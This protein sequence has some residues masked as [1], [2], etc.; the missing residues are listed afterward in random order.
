[1][2]SDFNLTHVLKYWS[3]ELKKSQIC[4]G[5]IKLSEKCI[6][7][8]VADVI[9][10]RR[11]EYDAYGVAQ[12]F[13][14]IYL[15]LSVFYL[16]EAEVGLWVNI[17]GSSDLSA[18]PLLAAA[19]RAGQVATPGEAPDEAICTQNGTSFIFLSA[20]WCSRVHELFYQPSNGAKHFAMKNSIMNN[21]L[22]WFYT[23]FNPPDSHLISLSRL[24]PFYP[25][26]STG[27]N[28]FTSSTSFYALF[29]T[30]KWN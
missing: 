18:D 11:Y 6:A 19:F 14:A 29:Y 8:K 16:K 7:R 22:G 24:L 30:S 1:M 5:F 28:T 17:M 3:E 23:F 2:K 9:F 25:H 26:L 4:I 10:Q 21:W 20:V 15:P 27:S 12:K 13:N